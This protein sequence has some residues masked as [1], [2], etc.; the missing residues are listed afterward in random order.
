M[1]NSVFSFGH[2]YV[3]VLLILAFHPKILLVNLN[4]SHVCMEAA[5][6]ICFISFPTIHEQQKINFNHVQSI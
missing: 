3:C 2:S 5:D 1:E 4:F 6:I